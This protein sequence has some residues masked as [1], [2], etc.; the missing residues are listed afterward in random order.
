MH[1]RLSVARC[2]AGYKGECGAPM[3]HDTLLGKQTSLRDCGGRRETPETTTRGCLYFAYAARRAVPGSTILARTPTP[4]RDCQC[5]CASFEGAARSPA[6][7]IPV[8][9][10]ARTGAKQTSKASDRFSNQRPEASHIAV[11]TVLWSRA[12]H[13]VQCWALWVYANEG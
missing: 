6:S 9:S 4:K 7:R 11:R 5:T 1:R 12:L 3:R 8:L 2:L 13:C 10:L